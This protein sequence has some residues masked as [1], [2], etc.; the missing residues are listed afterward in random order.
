MY[1]KQ[2]HSARYLSLVTEGACSRSFGS[3]REG[4]GGGEKNDVRIRAS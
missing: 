2:Q 4:G 3:N 1:I